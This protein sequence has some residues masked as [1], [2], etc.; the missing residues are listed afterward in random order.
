MC[1]PQT[2]L[3]SAPSTV[4]PSFVWYT[5]S[6]WQP[7]M[8]HVI[9]TITPHG[10]HTT[11]RKTAFFFTHVIA[12]KSTESVVGYPKDLGKCACCRSQLGTQ[13]GDCYIQLSVFKDKNMCTN[14]F[15]NLIQKFWIFALLKV[16]VCSSA[17][18]LTV[19]GTGVRFLARTEV[20]LITEATRN[21]FSILPPG[22]KSARA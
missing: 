6:R 8:P 14:V 13:T 11:C 21:Q 10:V 9:V 12:E 19:G 15:Q 1:T 16:L 7:L 5:S 2:A 22:A 18:V 3:Q 4:L 17:L 20:L